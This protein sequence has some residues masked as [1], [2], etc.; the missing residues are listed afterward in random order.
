MTDILQRG[1]TVRATYDGNTVDAVV[2]L[3]SPNG[4]SLVIAWDDGMLGG[5]L[6]VMPIW[7]EESG[8]YVSLIEG[9]PITLARRT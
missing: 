9:R 1:D 5:H 6:G 3:A 8:A 2:T 4:R 7:Q